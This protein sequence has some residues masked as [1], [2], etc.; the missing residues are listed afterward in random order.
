M[1]NLIGSAGSREDLEQMI[2]E[3]FYTTNI[4]ITDDMRVYNKKLDR[5][6]D[7][8]RIVQKRNRWRWELIDRSAT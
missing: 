4:I 5:Y 1:S 3:K 8:Y 7:G 2:N 6:L